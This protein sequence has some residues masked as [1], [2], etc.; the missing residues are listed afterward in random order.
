[1]AITTFELMKIRIWLL[2]ALLIIAN[3]IMAQQA[4]QVKGKE[5]TTSIIASPHLLNSIM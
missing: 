4:R 5:N 1:M 3:P 2:L